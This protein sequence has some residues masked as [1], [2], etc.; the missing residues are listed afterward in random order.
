MMQVLS[1]VMSAVMSVSAPGGN[2]PP[3]SAVRDL[4]LA[5]AS[6]DR[7]VRT[8][9]ARITS[10]LF[11]GVRR[12]RTFADLVTAVQRSNVIAYI[13]FAHQL[14]PLV[15]GRLALVSKGAGQRYIRIQVRS[16]L[17]RDMLISTIAHELQHAIEIAEAPGVRDDA[18]MKQLYH[19]I[20]VGRSDVQGFDTDAARLAGARVRRELRELS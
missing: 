13:E 20:G 4:H 9:D 2:A 16:M 11:E 10:A 14:P 1:L 8:T 18:S 3:P 6:P 5:L 7:R 15:E 17:P 19:R 12:S